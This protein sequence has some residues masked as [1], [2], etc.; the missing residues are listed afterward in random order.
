MMELETLE[1]E[2]SY[3]FKDKSLLKQALT[4]SSFSNEQRIRKWKNY[5]RIEFLGD[6]VLELVSSDYFYHTFPEETEGNLTK[7]RAA[8]VCEQALAIT[9]RQLKLG[10]Y[11]IFGKGEEANGGRERESIIADAVEAVIGAIYL[12][13]GI[14]KAREFIHRFVLNDLEHKRLF[15]DAKS[16]LQEYV[17]ETKAGEL[18]YELIKEEGPEHDKLFAMEAR[19]NGKTIGYGEGKSKKTAQQHAA[20]D[21]LLK[22]DGNKKDLR[23]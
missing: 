4:H 5:E 18:I 22:K 17:Q 15:Y 7:M 23:I 10:S 1:K 3:S 21:A 8:A 6:A 9:A 16:I 2:I 12:D 13:S 11:M 14:E 20:Y 19:L